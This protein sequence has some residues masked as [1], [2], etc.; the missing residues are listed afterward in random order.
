V[1]ALLLTQTEG[2]LD[3]LRSGDLEERRR[4]ERRLLEAG[5]AVQPKLEALRDEPDPELRAVVRRLLDLLK[6]RASL[7][8]S[9]D[10]AYPRT[11]ERLVDGQWRSVFVDFAA[12]R[13]ALPPAELRAATT[14]VMRVALRQGELDAFCKHARDVKAGFAAPA[15]AVAHREADA[16]SKQEI[17]SALEALLAT[18]FS[19]TTIV[20][21]R[22][23][24][25]V[26]LRLHA[27][28]A[29]LGEVVDIPFTC[30]TQLA[31]LDGR[32]VRP[33]ERVPELGVLIHR[34]QTHSLV[35]RPD[36]TIR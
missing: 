34:I 27:F 11:S 23:T 25:A 31:V 28:G 24:A 33:G 2:W 6:V 15:L 7:P 30:S 10:A 5:P 18:L 29:M 9:I 3:A 14:Q 32:V 16:A 4:A 19:A 17:W 13:S 21:E 20:E 12:K 36:K 22:R 35:L 8:P 1:L 26:D